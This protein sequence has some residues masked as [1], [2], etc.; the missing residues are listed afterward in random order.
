MT[1]A[2]RPGPVELSVVVSTRDR[3]AQL[4]DCLDSI[5]R[6]RCDAAWEIVVVDNGSSD[7][8][9]ETL[10]RFAATAPIAVQLVHEPRAGLGNA[11]NAG[12]AAARGAVLVFT[13]DDCYP[14]PDFLDAWRA[15]FADPAVG[16]GAGRILLHDPDDFPITISWVDHAVSLPAGAYIWPG[17]VQGANMAFRRTV[18]DR[19]GGFDPALGPGGVF[20]FEDLDISSRASMAGFAGGFF[21]EPTVYHHHRR[22]AGPAVDAL[23]RSYAH[24]RGAYYTSLLLQRG[25]RRRALGAWRDALVASVRERRVREFAL[26]LGGAAHYAAYRA[27]RGGEPRR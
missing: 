13:D 19:L 16:Y 12:V 23:R 9:P 26:E 1:A 7:A 11:R 25:W 27:L 3:A 14:A 17:L 15:V 6:L 2:A 22:R 5:A 4:P 21:T 10:A 18:L 8:T 24:A 20:N